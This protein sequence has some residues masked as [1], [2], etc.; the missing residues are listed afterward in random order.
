[1]QKKDVIFIANI[2]ASL[3]NEERNNEELKRLFHMWDI[4]DIYLKASVE[5]GFP[6]IS[7]YNAFMEY[8]MI[9][10]VSVDS[11]LSD[12]LHPNDEGHELIFK[13]ILE[14]LGLGRQIT[15]L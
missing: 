9:K 5:C 1:M 13:L 3:E 10:N 11:F 8:C 15:K 12:G 6:F 4:N 2:P 14:R 7:L